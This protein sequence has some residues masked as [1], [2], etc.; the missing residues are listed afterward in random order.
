MAKV[1]I[2]V[3]TAAADQDRE[4]LKVVDVLA[5]Q[6]SLDD[7]LAVIRRHLLDVELQRTP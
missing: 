7:L 4:G 2:I 3:I 6:F 5:K 1:P